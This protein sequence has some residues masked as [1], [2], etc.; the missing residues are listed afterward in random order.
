MCFKRRKKQKKEKPLPSTG[1]L[2]EIEAFDSY[3][4]TLG[5]R[6]TVV[7]EFGFG[8]VSWRSPRHAVLGR[9]VITHVATGLTSADKNIQHLH[10]RVSAGDNIIFDQL[11]FEII[12]F[13]C[14]SAKFDLLEVGVE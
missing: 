8:T 2:F 9:Y 10:L 6:L 3:G 13:D 12:S 1:L 11:R 7:P 4:K 14:D 5:K